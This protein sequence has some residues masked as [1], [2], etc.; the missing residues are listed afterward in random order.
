MAKKEEAK[1]EPVATGFT[2]EQFLQSR[3]WRGV[4]KDILS[5]TLKDGKRY[6]IAEAKQLVDKFKRG[7][8]K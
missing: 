8:V 2:K 4:D 7:E 1:Q 6:S 3:Q 5:I